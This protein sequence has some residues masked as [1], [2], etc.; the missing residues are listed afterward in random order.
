MSA[1]SI[2]GAGVLHQSQFTDG[3]HG[4]PEDTGSHF[5]RPDEKRR[6]DP[7]HRFVNENKKNTIYRE[8]SSQH[9]PKQSQSEQAEYKEARVRIIT[10]PVWF[11]VQTHQASRIGCC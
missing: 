7:K 11:N 6:A 2:T 9:H 4:R 1:S 3:N 10:G 5:V 8:V